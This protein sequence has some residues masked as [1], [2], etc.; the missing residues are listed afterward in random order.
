[1]TLKPLGGF[2][3]TL[4]DQVSSYMLKVLGNMNSGAVKWSL[5]LCSHIFI[6]PFNILI[7]LLVTLVYS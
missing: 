1:M 4:P 3:G 6:T 7:C 5:L 2:L